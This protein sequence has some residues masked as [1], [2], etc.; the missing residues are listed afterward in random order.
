M[1]PV[2]ALEPP[3][4]RVCVKGLPEELVQRL[5]SR[6]V[7]LGGDQ[8]GLESRVEVVSVAQ[9]KGGETA[10]GI[11]YAPRSDVGKHRPQDPTES[12]QVLCQVPPGRS[13]Q[14]ADKVV[15]G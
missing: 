3:G 4:I 11:D 6:G 7:L 5:E 1:L 12:Q 15:G 2:P 14:A 10:T 9:V 8:I 13:T